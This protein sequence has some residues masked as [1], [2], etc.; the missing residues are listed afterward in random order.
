MLF[1]VGRLLL[2]GATQ[3][4]GSQQMLSR[5]AESEATIVNVIFDGAA[6]TCDAGFL[7]TD[8]HRTHHVQPV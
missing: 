4:S 2:H 5:T 6:R 8:R 3:R 1:E 7:V